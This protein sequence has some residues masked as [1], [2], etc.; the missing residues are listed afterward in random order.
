MLLKN[1]ILRTAMA[2]MTVVI[3][4]LACSC[5]GN[6]EKLEFVSPLTEEERVYYTGQQLDSMADTERGAFPKLPQVYVVYADGSRS[7]DVSHSDKISFS[8][9]DL[10]KEGEQTVTV[11][12]RE[13]QNTIKATYGITVV[14]RDILY[15]E[16]DDTYHCLYPFT[17]GDKFVISETEE[18]GIKRG[19]TVTFRYNDPDNPSEAFFADDP[20]LEG[21]TFDT[22]GCLLDE[23]GRF[24]EAGTFT[25][26]AVYHGMTATYKICVAEAQEGSSETE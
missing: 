1:R 4:L 7:E 3:M 14:K 19:V 16:A 21:I 23:E 6:L 25:V 9:Y 22:S 8:G 11:T 15:I 5:K 17:V 26:Q 10:G 18:D 20:A 2:V 12:Y 24:T 13:G